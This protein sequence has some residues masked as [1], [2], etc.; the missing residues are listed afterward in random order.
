MNGSNDAK[1]EG[2]N[3]W[4]E[5]KKGSLFPAGASSP[6]TIAGIP[7]K[8]TVPGNEC[9]HGVPGGLQSN[10]LHGCTLCQVKGIK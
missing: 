2:T 9:I 6:A 8:W 4:T 3:K 7:A 5:T 10:T 1:N